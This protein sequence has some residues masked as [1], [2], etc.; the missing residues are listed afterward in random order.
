MYGVKQG[1]YSPINKAKY[2]GQGDPTYRSSWELKAFISLDK[3]PSILKWGSESIIIPYYDSTRNNE[4]HRY[5]VDLFFEVPTKDGKGE[6]WLIEIKPHNQSVAPKAS[7]RKSPEK[8]LYESLVV[9]RNQD[10]WAA[11]AKFCKRRN[12]HFGVWTEKGITKIC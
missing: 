5:I 12:W 4:Y 9:K 7:K 3:N 1:K 11:A 6:K 2:V 10:K 8:L